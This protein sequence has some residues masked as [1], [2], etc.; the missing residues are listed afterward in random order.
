MHQSKKFKSETLLAFSSGTREEYFITSTYQYS[1]AGLSGGRKLRKTNKKHLD[2]KGKT[3]FQKRW[4]LIYFKNSK[5]L[6]WEIWNILFS[7]LK[8]SEGK[9]EAKL[10]NFDEHKMFIMNGQ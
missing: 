9:K 6:Q 5:I 8:K 2:Q 1:T 3:C 4:L 7:Y 10:P